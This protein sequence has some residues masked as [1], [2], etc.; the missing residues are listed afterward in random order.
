[1]F[2][3]VRSPAGCSARQSGDTISAI[4]MDR[5]LYSSKAKG[6]SRRSSMR[7]ATSLPGETCP[8]S[9][10]NGGCESSGAAT[11]TGLDTTSLAIEL[12]CDPEPFQLSV[13]GNGVL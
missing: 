13:C 7:R 10:S 5:D 4:T 6:G 8:F 9:A 2:P 3:R 12:L 11:H 1:M